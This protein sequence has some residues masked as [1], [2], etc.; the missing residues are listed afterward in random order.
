VIVNAAPNRRPGGR[1]ARVRRAVLDAAADLLAE[2][3]LHD[4]DLATVAEH[5][6]VGRTTVYRRWQTMP[7]LIADLLDDMADQSRPRSDTG[8]LSGDLRANA[9]LVQQ[10]LA[11]PRQGALFK[12]LIAG[13]GCDDRTAEAL[14]GFYDRRIDEWTPCVRDA[15]RRGEVPPRTD[16]RAVIMAVSSPLYYQHLTR[17][18]PPTPQD[19]LRA[20]RAACTAARAGVYRR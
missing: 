13:A 4:L 11:D 3:G 9:V 12:A 16:A 19:A 18:T 14:Q 7:L 8:S 20:S 10:T 5:A 15:R 17:T 1:T 6:G 2:R